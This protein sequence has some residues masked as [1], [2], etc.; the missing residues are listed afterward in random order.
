MR[1]GE[2]EAHMTKVR[3]LLLGI[4]AG[5]LLVGVATGCGLVPDQS[6]QEAKKKVEQKAQQA[7]KEVK[8]KP[9]GKTEN[10][11]QEVKK[12]VNE[13]LKKVEAQEQQRQKDEK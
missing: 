9:E 12:K 10:A 3:V 7:K 4:V 1:E 8:N 11:K 13:L 5:L 6:K 2:D